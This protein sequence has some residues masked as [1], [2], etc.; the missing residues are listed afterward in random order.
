[1]AR[2]RST[3]PP[4]RR[5][6]RKRA[7]LEVDERREQLL[8]IGLAAFSET[9]Y[10]L[11]AIDDVAKA[12]RVSKGLLYHYF[13]NKRAFYAAVVERAAAQL[14]E[15]TQTDPKARPSVRLRQ[16]IDAYLAYVK[17]HEAAYLALMQG[18]I[19]S[20]PTVADIVERTRQ[21]FLERILSGVPEPSSLLK[22]ALRGWLGYVEATVLVWLQEGGVASESLRNHLTEVVIFVLS[23][24]NE[25]SATRR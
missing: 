5:P 20:D 21:A 12:A 6:A 4:R 2:T 1:M 13:P 24:V 16:G 9:P 11:V 8:A 10:D 7:R 15:R 22:L 18:G 3:P 23:R 25:L 19:G 14:L 17:A